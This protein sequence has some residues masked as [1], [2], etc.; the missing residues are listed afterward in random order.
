[1]LKFIPDCYKIIMIIKL[2]LYILSRIDVR[3]KKCVRKPLILIHLQFNLFQI[4]I[5][6]KKCVIRLLI[7]VLLYWTL[8]RSDIKT[9]ETSDKVVSKGSFMLNYC[10]DRYNTQEMCNKTVMLFCQHLNLFLIGLLLIKCLINLIMLYS[11]TMT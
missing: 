5:W 8:F 3:H 4:N 2:M 1:M 7:F 9:Q 11:L 10:L 6:L